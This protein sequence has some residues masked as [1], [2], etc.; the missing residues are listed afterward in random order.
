MSL[1]RIQRLNFATVSVA[2]SLLFSLTPLVGNRT[3]LADTPLVE[4]N[5]DV[6]PILSDRCFRCHGPDEGERA[7][8]LRLDVEEIATRVLDSGVTAVVPGDPERSELLLRVTHDDADMRMPP[9]DAGKSLSDREIRT[10][11]SW[12]KQGAKWSGHWSFH[13]PTRPVLP[14]MGRRWSRTPIDRFVY[15]KLQASN[16]TPSPAATREELIRRVTFDLTGLPPTPAEID[17]FIRD[18][19]P[20]AYERLVDRLL[21][22]PRYGEHM[23]RHWLDVARYGDTHGL[24]LDNERSIWPYRDWVIQA[25][26][27]NMPFDQFTIEQLAGDLLDD[28]THSQLVATGFNR[29]NVTT[30]EGGSIDEEY[31]FRY[32]VDRV[33]TTST[34]WMGLTAGCAVCHDHKFDPISQKEFYRLYAYFYSLTEKAMDGNA[35]LPPPVIKSPTAGQL[36]QH[37]AVRREIEGIASAIS[38]RRTE[39]RSAFEA[40]E[41]RARIDATRQ[42]APD[43]HILHA[44]FDAFDG[45]RLEFGNDVTGT[46]L[47]K[48]SSDAGKFGDAFRFDGSTTIEVERFAD[49]GHDDPFSFG[50]WIYR[51]SDGHMA[52][53]SKMNDSKGVRGYDL[54]VADGKVFVHLIHDWFDGNAIRVNTQQP[55]GREKWQHVMATYDGSGKASGIHIY[56]GGVQQEL[57]TTHDDLHGS[58]KTNKPF[59]IGRRTDSAPFKGMIDELRVFHRELSDVEV[60]LVA[61]VDPIGEILSLDPQER[62][63]RQHRDLLNHFLMAEDAGYRELVQE[64]AAA[65]SRKTRIENSF[66]ST[67]IMQELEKPRQAY[68]LTRGQ[69]DQLGD[70]VSPGGLKVLP[71]I[72]AA[73]GNR[74]SRLDLAR[75]L[76]DPAHPLTA[77]VTVNRIWQQYFGT[78]IVKTSGDFGSQGDWPSHPALLDWLAV[79]FVESEWNVKALHRLIVS[80]ATYRQSSHASAEAYRSDPENRLLARGPRYRLDA[81]QIRDNAL[82]VSGLLNGRIGGKSVRPYQPD[83][84]WF[85]VGYTSSNTARFKQDNGANL[86]RRG[87]YTFWKRTSP[88]PMMQ[89][90]DAPSRE[91][92]TVRRPRTNTPAAALVLMNDVQFVEAARHFASRTLREAE[93]NDV[94]R[95]NFAFRWVT[96]RF[97]TSDE[98]SL[99]Q[100]LLRDFRGHY[101]A[102]PTD[103]SQ[104]LSVG[105]TELHPELD[106]V[107]HAA[108]TML[109][110]TLLNL[111]ETVTK[112]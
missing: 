59:R 9:T 48:S 100:G 15:A 1:M 81:E 75:W 80:S 66:A 82:L 101:L 12:I 98:L 109:C 87:M 112:Q 92:C 43:D 23:A 56:V 90:F 21:D 7:T 37:V 10:L 3:A 93:A 51:V 106:A 94:A 47:G 84:L 65:R 58:I 78:G 71:P 36:R 55:I 31:L 69:Y 35:L 38:N 97:P 79:E 13:R 27:A 2:A 91:V 104:L 64:L 105:D 25:I 61:G 14:T 42:R 18:G 77:R 89:I 108:W 57:E 41:S 85:A 26:N 99:V 29:C 73:N 17:Q 40:W 30:S 62:S 54:Y 39:M 52:I 102:H 16:L 28:P 67:L 111:D 68:V 74:S 86:H 107:E 83:G 6:R 44:T 19:S 53:L 4:F 34:V 88:P 11:E 45:D 70:P 60:G 22:S 76:V 24:H 5:R 8:D 95:I 103:A 49:F 32:A 96:S 20:S 110:S 72:S 46:V 33:E 50:A 63:E